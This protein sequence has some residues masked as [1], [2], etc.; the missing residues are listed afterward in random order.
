MIGGLKSLSLV[1]AFIL[2]QV[3]LACCKWFITSVIPSLKLSFI[4][5]SYWRQ[6]QKSTVF[7]TRSHTLRA[8]K[9][10]KPVFTPGKFVTQEISSQLMCGHPTGV[11]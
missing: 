2:S 5:S 4:K 1:V 6:K 3:P 9:L 7:Y 10:M 11:F 8:W